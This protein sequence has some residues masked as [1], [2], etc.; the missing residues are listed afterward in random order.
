[1]IDNMIKRIGD[2][3][4]QVICES[5]NRV[6]IVYCLLYHLLYILSGHSWDNTITQRRQGNVPGGNSSSK[7]GDH[8][9]PE[10]HLPLPSGQVQSPSL[11]IA[12]RSIKGVK[13]NNKRLFTNLECR[14]CKEGGQETQEHIEECSG[15]NYER[16]GLDMS[17]WEGKVMF[18]RRMI[19]KLAAVA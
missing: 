15:C 2:F 14:Y 13:V 3:G 8:S 1:M 17:R 6:I 4:C 7:L 5:S 12:A 11:K 10:H 16:R 19:A 18:W 9:P